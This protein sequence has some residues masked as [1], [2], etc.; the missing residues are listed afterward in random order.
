MVIKQYWTQILFLALGLLAG[1]F[2]F[3]DKRTTVTIPEEKGEFKEQ[4]PVY[5]TDTVTVYKT[6]WKTTTDTIE[7]IT[8]NPVNDS[9][10]LAYQQTKDSLNR[11]KMYLDAIQIKQFSNTFED[12]YQ[13]I[14]ITGEVQG[15]LN[16][17]K[18]KYTIKERQIEVPVKRFGI[19]PYI[20]IDYQGKVSGGI[21]LSYSIWEF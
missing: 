9:L 10:A 1:Y 19:G 17:I 18:P 11:F 14:N 21:G 8:E 6:K 7:I 16:W 3:A 15:Q 13:I 5:I 20:G 2:L 12:E 4:K